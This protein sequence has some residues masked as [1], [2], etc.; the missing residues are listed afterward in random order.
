MFRMDGGSSLPELASGKLSLTGSPGVSGS[1][2][3]GVC[4]RCAD[5]ADARMARQFGLLEQL[6]A[7]TIVLAEAVGQDATKYPTSSAVAAFVQ[8]ART[9]RQTI[10]LERRIEAEREAAERHA[11]AK[12]RWLAVARANPEP[13]TG[14]AVD[15]GG[16]AGADEDGA[17]DAGVEDSGADDVGVDAGAGALGAEDDAM[18]EAGREDLLGDLRER[19]DCRDAVDELGGLP[20]GEVVGRICE[21][22]GIAADLS[23]FTPQEMG[24]RANWNAP[25][26]AQPPAR[27]SNAAFEAALARP[28]GKSAGLIGPLV[29][30][31]SRRRSDATA[32]GDAA[33]CHAPARGGGGHDPTCVDR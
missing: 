10:A 25:P 31:S 3:V 33:A 1:S 23:C 5:A 6:G 26:L 15:A 22:L 19:P 13:A 9:L 27:L 14:D 30:R 17:E 29:R 4:A 21:M 11:A 20:S 2:G 32:A 18:A 24:R 28:A 12:P 16:G 7:V 8:V